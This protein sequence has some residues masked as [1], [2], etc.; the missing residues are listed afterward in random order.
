[1]DVAIG[2]LDTCAMGSASIV[3]L[4][5]R[6]RVERDGAALVQPRGRK[7]WAVLAYLALAERPVPR[8]RLASL[9]FGDADDPLGALRWTLAELRRVLGVPGAFRGD[10][11][12]Q[13]LGAGIVLDVEELHLG[14]G[15]LGLVR[16]EL[17]ERAE[18][19]AGPVFDAWLL[20]ERRRLAGICE[21]LLH[22]AAL[23]ELGL[24]RPREAAVLASRALE[25]SP[26]ED[27]LHEL[28]VRCLAAA[29]DAGAARHHAVACEVLFRREL[30]RAPDPK[31][32]RAADP[33]E[34]RDAPG[35]RAAAVGQLQ[36]GLAAIDAGAVEPGIECLRMAAAEARAL[37][38]QGV[39]AQVLLE[40]GIALVHAVRG[41]DE[42]GVALLHE[43][44]ALSERA[45]QRRVALVACRELGYVAV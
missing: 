34:P 17:L 6:P 33:A 9:L 8:E 22:H 40:L 42:E 16:G 2:A 10:P 5:G 44:L 27:R 45:G 32:R 18:P 12:G 38:D 35:D 25:L 37:G 1:M 19:D 30:G 23:Q 7:S 41:R 4:L 29:G 28:L 36:A 13:D 3:R 26:F 11:V 39:L 31:V 20:V 14:R 43:A 15:D 21:G 24:S